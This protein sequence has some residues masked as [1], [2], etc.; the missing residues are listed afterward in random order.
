MNADPDPQNLVNADPDPG[1]KITNFI[2]NHILEV[3]KKKKY[4]QICTLTLEISYFSLDSEL[5]NMISYNSAF[6]SDRIRI[7]ITDFTFC[8]L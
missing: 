6:A 5:K 4:F 3:K 7:H 8:L 1:Q 2:S